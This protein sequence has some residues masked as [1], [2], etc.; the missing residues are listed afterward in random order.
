MILIDTGP[1]VAA[2]DPHE[3]RHQECI[4]LLAEHGTQY[5]TTIVC[6]TEALYLIGESRGWNGQNKLL[7]LIEVG[8]L[9]VAGISTSE[10][11]RVRRLMDKYRDTPMDFADASIVIIAERTAKIVSS[12]LTATLEFFELIVESRSR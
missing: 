9:S 5:L 4:K 2:F 1:L 3:P 7:N 10:I 12:L 8:G 11:V 6:L